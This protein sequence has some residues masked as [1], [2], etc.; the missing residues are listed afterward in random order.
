MFEFLGIGRH[1]LYKRERYWEQIYLDGKS[2]RLI[3]CLKEC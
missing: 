3:P 1:H 2:V